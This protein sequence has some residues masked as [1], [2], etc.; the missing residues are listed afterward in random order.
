MMGLTALFTYPS[1]V[2]ALYMTCG[3]LQLQCM[4][5]MWVMKKGS[6]QM[7]KTPAGGPR[8]EAVLAV[9]PVRSAIV[10]I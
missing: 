9:Q 10:I 8:K 1:H 6:Q 7:M 5:R 2:K 3:I 4:F